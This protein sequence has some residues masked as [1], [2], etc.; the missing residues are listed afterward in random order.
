MTVHDRRAFLALAGSAVVTATAGC[1]GD[2]DDDDANDDP[3]NG[4]PTLDLGDVPFYQAYV[5]ASA[6]LT[7]EP[8]MLGHVDITAMRDRWPTEI[9]ED[10]DIGEIATAIGVD[11]EAITSL[12]FVESGGVDEF[13]EL[14]ILFG[15][16]DPESIVEH[17]ASM[18]EAVEH[19]DFLVIDESIAIAPEA[20][21]LS[22]YY[23]DAIDAKA[24]TATR[25]TEDDPHWEQGARLV[26]EPEMAMYASDPAEDPWELLAMALDARD[27]DQLDLVGYAIFADEATAE[28]E[29][30]TVEDEIRD[31]LEDGT[32]DDVYRV[33]NVIIVEAR[34]DPAFID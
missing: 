31:D 1:L 20:I 6:V 23:G 22:V 7:G 4:E 21:I 3:E 2:D 11:L 18:D 26:G 30:E 34:V 19:G 10:F 32:I 33:E 9:Y 17:L 16:Y 5:P 27:D 28:A 8:T 13:S 12:L 29:H 15:S 24:S 14:A 25:L